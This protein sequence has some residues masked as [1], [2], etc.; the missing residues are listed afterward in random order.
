VHATSDIDSAGGC[1]GSVDEYQLADIH[2]AQALL[3]AV[4][5]IG[6]VG[7]AWMATRLPQRGW[8]VLIGALL[9]VVPPLIALATHTSPADWH[10]GLCIA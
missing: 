8:S 2:H 4:I 10:G 9:C 3:L 7:W 5:V 6:V 1:N